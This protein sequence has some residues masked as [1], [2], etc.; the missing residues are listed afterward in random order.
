[1]GFFNDSSEVPEIIMEFLRKKLEIL[2]YNQ[3]LPLP[4]LVS[5]LLDD[6]IKTTESLK[7]AKE[8]IEKLL[9]VC[10]CFCFDT[11]FNVFRKIYGEYLIL[12]EISLGASNG[13]LQVR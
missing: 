4:N 12:G 7:D 8:T 13:A 1:L 6:L 11:V 3:S 2:G 10:F 9:E 5:A